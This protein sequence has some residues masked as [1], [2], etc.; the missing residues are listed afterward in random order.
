MHLSNFDGRF[1]LVHDGIQAQ[2][3]TRHKHKK[4][5]SD[6]RR[7]SGNRHVDLH[8]LPII[9]Q[10]GQLISNTSVNTVSVGLLQSN[11]VS[12]MFRSQ[13]KFSDGRT[14]RSYFKRAW[15][16]QRYLTRIHTGSNKRWYPMTGYVFCFLLMKPFSSEKVNTKKNTVSGEVLLW[17]CIHH[18][19]QSVRVLADV[20]NIVEDLGPRPDLR[21][22]TS[23][24]DFNDDN[25]I[26][27]YASCLH[28][29]R[30]V[31]CWQADLMVRHRWGC[32]W[33]FA[34][35]ATVSSLTTRSE[36]HRLA[37]TVSK[38]DHASHTHFHVH[39]VEMPLVSCGYG[40][41]DVKFL[42]W[43]LRPSWIKLGKR[44]RR[45]CQSLLLRH[46]FTCQAELSLC[47]VF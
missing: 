28:W 16:G 2:N 31:Q 7:R 43:K 39:D 25:P 42:A 18:A 12:G 35:S 13:Q 19:I 15:V 22:P 23:R 9:A 29:A 30:A 1:Y 6:Q 46:A 32:R 38:I 14:S 45:D 21:S 5:C 44:L 8:V 20:Q 3:C 11:D 33:E 26:T 4:V 24:S 17:L 10:R 37:Q 40:V 27:G 34:M 47:P 36:S 41:T